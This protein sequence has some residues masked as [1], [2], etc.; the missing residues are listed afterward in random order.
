VALERTR[1]VTKLWRYLRDPGVAAWRKLAGVAAVA[2]V[3][4]PLDLI[5]DG[6]PVLGW[7]DDAGV[8]AAAAAFLVAE[9]R[10]HERMLQREG[11]APESPGSR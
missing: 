2:Y 1:T 9:I 7:L 10:R 8:I 11:P 4:W 6:I 5:P 3:I